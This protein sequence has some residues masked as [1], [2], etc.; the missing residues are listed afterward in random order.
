MHDSSL[1]LYFDRNIKGDI[2]GIYNA[3]GTQIAKVSLH[4]WGKYT[5]KT[6]VSNSFSSYNPIRYRGYYYDR[7]TT[8]YYLNARY[9]DP[10][11]RRFISPDHVSSLNPSAA[12]GLNL[13]SYANNF[14]CCYR[15]VGLGSRRIWFVGL[16][17]KLC[18][19]L[20][21]YEE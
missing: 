17:K 13:Y 9:Y 10:S 7:E 20:V 18:R 16:H 12:N 11:W 21:K 1:I 14:N 8:L 6:L 5:P 2:I 4:S 15:I 3:S 19:K